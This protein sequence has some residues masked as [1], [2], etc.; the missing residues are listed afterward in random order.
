MAHL[1]IKAENL[2]IGEE[3]ALKIAD[4]DL[5]YIEGDARLYGKGTTNSR[6]PEIISDTV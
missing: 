2:L 6:A 5:S 3:F 1:D 4:L